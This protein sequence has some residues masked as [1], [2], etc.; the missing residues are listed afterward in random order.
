[1]NISPHQY[2]G[3][4]EMSRLL[5]KAGA[6][7]SISEIYGLI[8]GCLAAPHMV[9]PSQYMPLIF[10]EEGGTYDSM[11][12]ANKVLGNLMSLWNVLADLDPESNPV[13]FPDIKYYET[14]EGLTERLKDDYSLIDSFII[15][16]DL[17]HTPE[18][19]FGRGGLDALKRL[20]EAGGLLHEYAKVIEKNL[21]KNDRPEEDLEYIEQ[22]EYV[23]AVCIAKI[24]ISLRPARIKE[25]EQM[26]LMTDSVR[27][28]KVPRNAPCPC[29]SGKKYKKCC[30]L[31]H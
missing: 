3:D 8:Y 30:G 31:M 29:G 19:D 21:K 15:G 6:R 4:A 22:L 9:V 10:G 17:G 25:A 28:D 12:E 16:L 26:R 11:E 18:S 27:S 14:Y 2:C 1:M 7:L 5:E 23:V 24:N 20:S 13:Y